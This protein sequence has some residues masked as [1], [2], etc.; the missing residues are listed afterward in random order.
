MATILER[1]KKIQNPAWIT[2]DPFRITG[3][4]EK[5][6]RRN[7]SLSIRELDDWPFSGVAWMWQSQM[8]PQVIR[9]TEWDH[10][11]SSEVLRLKKEFEKVERVHVKQLC[12]HVTTPLTNV[13]RR[14]SEFLHILGFQVVKK[15]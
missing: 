10:F 6:T 12:W 14:Q 8:G 1:G 4:Q 7:T 2:G 9:R 11:E 3:R 15:P 13:N 5:T